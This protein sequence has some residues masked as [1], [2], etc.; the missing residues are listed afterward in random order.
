MIDIRT[1]NNIS[2]FFILVK[3]GDEFSISLK[4][5]PSAGY[6]WNVEFEETILELM[7]PKDICQNMETMGGAVE[8]VFTFRAK[9]K[10][11]TKINMRYKREW[12]TK[13]E[14]TRQ[15]NIEIK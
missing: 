2:P 15:Y 7:K 4:S 13:I 11:N 5:I 1:G 3:Q 6:T 8:K 9:K 12:E 14:E 10:G